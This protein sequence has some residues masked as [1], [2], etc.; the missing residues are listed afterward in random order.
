MTTT[1]FSTKMEVWLR[2]V[3]LTRTIRR[4]F[5]LAPWLEVVLSLNSFAGLSRSNLHGPI[6]WTILSCTFTSRFKHTVSL[7]YFE[8]YCPSR[9]SAMDWLTRPLFDAVKVHLLLDNTR[10]DRELRIDIRVVCFMRLRKKSR[11]VEGKDWVSEKGERER[12]GVEIDW[13]KGNLSL[14]RLVKRSEIFN[15][16]RREMNR[17]HKPEK[18]WMNEW[19]KFWLQEI[20]LNQV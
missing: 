15:D 14:E 20:F 11:K 7:I 13:L 8:W 9:R 5:S 1:D 16:L 3:S 12:C 10:Q 17:A 19:T 6:A 4:L 2:W 18:E